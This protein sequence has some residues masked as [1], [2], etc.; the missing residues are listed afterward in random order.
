M[1]KSYFRNLQFKSRNFNNLCYSSEFIKITNEVLK[2]K[3]LLLFLEKCINTNLQNISLEYT[4][5]H[6]YCQKD[7]T[8][9]SNQSL[10]DNIGNLTLFEGK[11]VKIVIK[12]I[13][14]WV[15]K[16]MIRK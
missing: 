2:I 1:T 15:K 6:I 16:Y 12:A 5:E 13:V 10:I 8:K 11:I 14:L 4:L 3:N 7:R 9:L